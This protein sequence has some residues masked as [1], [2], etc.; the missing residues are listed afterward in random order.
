MVDRE[1]DNYVL[2]C[3]APFPLV[4]GPHRSDAAKFT[5]YLGELLLPPG[6]QFLENSIK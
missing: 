3:L 6:V 2:V 4:I 1:T 5:V